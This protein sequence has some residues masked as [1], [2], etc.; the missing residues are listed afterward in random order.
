MN[1]F[2]S[3]PTAKHLE[4]LKRRL[5]SLK[6]RLGNLER[7]KNEK[8]RDLR[9]NDF[10]ELLQQISDT[11]D[12]FDSLSNAGWEF[13]MQNRIHDGHEHPSILTRENPIG[14]RLTALYAELETKIS[15]DKHMIQIERT[16]KSLS[17]EIAYVSGELSSISEKYASET[18]N[19]EML[20]LQE[21]NP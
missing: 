11:T 6:R 17:E 9:D 18:H 4:S 7:A 3:Q 21:N 15:E 5:E 19:Q 8:E 16:M 1:T 2:S 20:A 14:T 13:E 10:P 12:R